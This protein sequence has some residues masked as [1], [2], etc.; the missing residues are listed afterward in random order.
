[1]RPASLLELLVVVVYDPP[2]PEGAFTLR[3]D[4]IGLSWSADV[5]LARVGTSSNFTAT[6]QY[7]AAQRAATPVVAMKA[8]LDGAYAVGANVELRLSAAARSTIILKPW[9]GKQGGRLV[10]LHDVVSPRLGNT[11]DVVVYL[12][13][14]YAENSA[15]DQYPLLLLQDGQNLFNA[16]TSFGG[17]AWRCDRTVDELVAEGK[18]HEVVMVGI[19]NACAERIDEYTY[20]VDA[21]YGGGNAAAYLA[22]VLETVLPLVR[23]TFPRTVGGALS[24]GGSSLGG[25]FACWAAWTHPEMFERAICMSSSFWWNKSVRVHSFPRALPLRHPSPLAHTAS[26]CRPYN[27][28]NDHTSSYDFNNTIVANATAPRALY[29]RIYLDTGDTD[30]DTDIHPATIAVDAH[31]TKLGLDPF[32]YLDRGG[33][34]DEASWGARFHVPMAALYPPQINVPAAV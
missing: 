31:M 4:G 18:M 12:P 3:G 16:S 23:A 26:R 19:D 13:P 10:V 28:D 24:V 34:H 21:T 2:P 5:A 14:S 22:F 8:L 7:D 25:L 17:I 1:M 9:F 27:A 20:S 29:E 11:R 6:L 33:S 30:G 15:V 32:Y